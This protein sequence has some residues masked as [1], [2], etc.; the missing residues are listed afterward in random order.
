MRHPSSD[1]IVHLPM[2]R[3]AASMSLSTVM[4]SLS[5]TTPRPYGICYFNDFLASLLT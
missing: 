5:S 1:Q 2:R 3:A 4:F